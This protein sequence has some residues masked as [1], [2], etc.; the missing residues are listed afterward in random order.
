M[1]KL[2]EYLNITQEQLDEL[3]LEIQEDSGSSGEMVYSYWFEVPESVSLEIM[4]ATGWK[5]GQII[6][7]IPLNAIE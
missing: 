6:N 4:E 3:G 7:N 1:K 5:P 2:A